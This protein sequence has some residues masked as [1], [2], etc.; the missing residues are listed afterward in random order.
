[1]SKK[2]IFEKG[3]YLVML[4]GMAIITLGFVLMGMETSEY[5]FGDLGLT[6]GPVVVLI[7]FGVEFFAIFRKKKTTS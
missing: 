1:M 6:V 2:L 3:N 4:V 5:G 7:G